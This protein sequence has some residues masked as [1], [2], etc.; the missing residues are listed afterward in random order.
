[1]INKRK[2]EEKNEKVTYTAVGVSHGISSGGMLRW[3]TAGTTFRT[4]CGK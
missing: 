1:V 3:S 4:T 2:K